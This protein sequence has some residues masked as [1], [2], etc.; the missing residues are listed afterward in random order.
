MRPA[1]W[2]DRHGPGCGQTA[3][4]HFRAA[5]GI[6]SGCA[7][8]HNRTVLASRLQVPT[9]GGQPARRDCRIMAQ[10]VVIDQLFMVWESAAAVRLRGAR[11][12]ARQRRVQGLSPAALTKHDPIFTAAAMSA[13]RSCIRPTEHIAMLD[14]QPCQVLRV[15]RREFVMFVDWKPNRYSRCDP[16]RRRLSSMS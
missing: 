15:N 3:N 16:T 13:R 8:Y 1:L 11:R 2:F 4:I 12:F 7:T 5:A 9:M 6:R 10:L 14:W